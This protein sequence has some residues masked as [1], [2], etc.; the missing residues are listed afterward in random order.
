MRIDGDPTEFGWN[1]FPG[2]TSLEF[3]HE[4]QKD[5]QK[6]NIEPENFEVEVKSNGMETKVTLLKEN[7]KPQLVRW[8]S[9][10]GDLG[11][12]YSKVFLRWLVES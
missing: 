11:I 8:W 5:L 12:Q 1:I 3:V 2:L 6:Q 7:G 10:S 9:D 4:I